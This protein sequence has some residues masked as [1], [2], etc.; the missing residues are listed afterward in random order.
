MAKNSKARTTFNEKQ[1]LRTAENLARKGKT[2][3]KRHRNP[4]AM[5]Y[6]RSK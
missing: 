3:K 1:Y 2:N 5:K 6:D 4:N